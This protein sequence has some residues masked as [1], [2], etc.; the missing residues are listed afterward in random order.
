MITMKP[1][2][3][4]IT[5]GSQHHLCG[6]VLESSWSEKY[7]DDSFAKTLPVCED[8]LES[9][10]LN[11]GLDAKNRLMGFWETG[12]Q[13]IESPLEMIEVE[14]NLTQTKRE[15]KTLREYLVEGTE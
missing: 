3:I 13:I 10:E 5:G 1:K 8:C 11:Y 15:L 2:V 4:H 9:Y 14:V 6:D 12:I 7:L